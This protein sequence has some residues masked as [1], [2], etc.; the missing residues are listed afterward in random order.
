MSRVQLA[1]DVP[2]LDVAIDYYTK[3]FGTPPHKVRD[4]YANFAVAEPPLKLVLF[5]DASATRTGLNHLGV[6]VEDPAA[7]EAATARFREAGLPVRVQE[8]NLCCHAVQDK[9]WAADANGEEWEFYAI[10][11]DQ[12]E[13][14]LPDGA[15]ALACGTDDA[16]GTDVA[17][18]AAG[19]AA[20][21]PIV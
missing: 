1:L 4:G 2:D 8:S 13:A 6:E 10:L 3:L 17:G 12:P 9:V 14:V 18:T 16:C 20:G 7:V 11:D 19:V 15:D 21:L 5:E